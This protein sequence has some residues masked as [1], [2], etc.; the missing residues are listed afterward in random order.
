MWGSRSRDVTDV[1]HPVYLDASMMID[2][3][4]SY[5]DGVTF[6]SDV[7][8]KIDIGRK[9]TTDVEG[10][11]GTPSL[12]SLV[13][14]TLSGSGKLAREKSSAETT[15]SK[16]V[17]QHTVA[18]LF[19]RLRSTLETNNA[20][21]RIST[22]DALATLT[23]GTLVECSGVIDRN[24]MESVSQ[25][26]EDFRPYAIVQKRSEVRE[27]MDREDYETE[28]AFEDAVREEAD[29][30]YRGT[31]EMFE[32]VANDLK[33]GQI[34]DLPMSVSAGF[35]VLIAANR[36]YYTPEV[37]AAMLGGTFKV[38]GKVSGIDQASG[39][40]VPIVRRGVI[41]LIGEDRL[42]LLVDSMKND[43]IDLR[44]PPLTMT[45]PWIQLI[46]LAIFV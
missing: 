13:G 15:E 43:D 21:E 34:I 30:E 9:R 5:D 12:A 14:L 25:L 26:Y 2:F 22:I 28:Q 44:I 33:K 24:P 7:A 31:D 16:F 32:V 38:V 6:S 35:S 20:V 23:P 19:N 37:E 41:G 29:R 42:Q 17:R 40:T 1:V 46:P 36:E 3:L 27:E 45:S 4:A 18:S 10:K 39:Q 8:R 11:A